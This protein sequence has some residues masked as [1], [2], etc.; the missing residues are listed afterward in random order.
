MLQ[1]QGETQQ[2]I[3]YIRIIGYIQNFVNY[4]GT[5]ARLLD[6]GTAALNNENYNTDIPQHLGNEEGKELI[7]LEHLDTIRIQHHFQYIEIIE[8]YEEE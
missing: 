1:L 5:Y 6:S 8:E 4:S 2:T 7:S 3:S